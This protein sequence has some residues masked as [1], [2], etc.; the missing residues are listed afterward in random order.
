MN[1][2]MFPIYEI[3]YLYENTLFRWTSAFMI[4]GPHSCMPCYHGII[5]AILD[6]SHVGVMMGDSV[7]DCM[8]QY[9]FISYSDYEILLNIM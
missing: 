9:I 7:N 1:D 4:K 5:K 2:I 8:S 3:V 6:Y